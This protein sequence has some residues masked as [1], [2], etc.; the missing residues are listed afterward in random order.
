MRI[1]TAVR[2]EIDYEAVVVAELSARN[3]YLPPPLADR[4]LRGNVDALAERCK[5]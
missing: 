5:P 3:R 4:A 2:A 1:P